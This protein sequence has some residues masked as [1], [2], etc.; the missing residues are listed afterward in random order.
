M[1]PP[2]RTARKVPS[3]SLLRNFPNPLPSLPLFLSPYLPTLHLNKKRWKSTVLRGLPSPEWSYHWCRTTASCHSWNLERFRR[4]QNIFHH[5]PKKCILANTRTPSFHKIYCLCHSLGW[6]ISV[7]G[8]TV[9]IKKRPLYVS[10]Y[11]EKSPRDLLGQIRNCISARFDNLFSNWTR[12]HSS[13]WARLRVPRDI[14][15]LL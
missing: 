9:W 7:K 10:E 1:K 3:H 15:N 6:A 8:H 5:W 14:R 12:A 11:Y 13:P 2:S 4:G